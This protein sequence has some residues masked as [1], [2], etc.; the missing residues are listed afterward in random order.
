MQTAAGLAHDAGLSSG[1]Q[2]LF[3]GRCER[4]GD[5]RPRCLLLG[6]IEGP[7]GEGGGIGGLGVDEGVGFFFVRSG[8]WIWIRIRR[9]VV[10]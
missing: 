8:G 5:L 6:F 10:P 2:M 3:D 7:I 1:S 9:Y 4:D